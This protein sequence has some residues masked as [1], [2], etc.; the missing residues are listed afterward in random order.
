MHGWDKSS[1]FNIF[2]FI[3]VKCNY[4]FNPSHDDIVSFPILVLVSLENTHSLHDGEFGRYWI[5]WNDENVSLVSLYRSQLFIMSVSHGWPS[6]KDYESLFKMFSPQQRGIM[7]KEAS[8]G[9]RS[10]FEPA[11]FLNFSTFSHG[12]LCRI[13]YDLPWTCIAKEQKNQKV[14]P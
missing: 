4:I 13:G 11:R 1:S 9:M 14:K 7:P 2:L 3:I 8:I 6:V 5:T 12:K 10:L